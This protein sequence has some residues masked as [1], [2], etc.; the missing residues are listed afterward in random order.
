MVPGDW[1]YG[2]RPVGERGA[3]KRGQAT[4]SRRSH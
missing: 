1:K 2:R 4:L 3:Q